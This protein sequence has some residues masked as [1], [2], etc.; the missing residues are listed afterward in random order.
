MLQVG[1]SRVRIST[2]SL[3]SFNLPNLSSR[4]MAMGFTQ[5]LTKLSTKRSF[6]G[7]AWPARMADNLT[8]ICEPKSLDNVRS[9]TTHNPIGLHGLLQG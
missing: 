8:D 4:T 2:M 6:L 7:T 3:N 1:R 5:R 9:S